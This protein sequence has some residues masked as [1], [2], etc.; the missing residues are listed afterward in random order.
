MEA[1]RT[2]MTTG[3][4]K[5]TSDATI[6]TSET[7]KLGQVEMKSQELGIIKETQKLKE[8]NELHKIE[9]EHTQRNGEGH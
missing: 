3:K 9:E 5:V 7:C 8:V 4:V 6:V 2:A 1:V